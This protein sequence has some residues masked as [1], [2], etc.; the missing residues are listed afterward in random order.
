[1]RKIITLLLLPLLIL[2]LVSCE[3]RKLD[4]N[5]TNVIFYTGLNGSYVDTY[6]DVTVGDKI[7]PPEEPTRTG[8]S[9]LGWYKDI[10]YQTLWEFDVDTVESSLVLYAKWAALVWTLDFVTN[11]LLAEEFVDPSKVPATFDLNKDTYLPVLRRPGG[12]FRGWIL[13]P[14]EEYTLDMDVYR[15]SSELPI[16]LTNDFVLYPVFVN[17]K[18]LVQYQPRMAGVSV[19]APKTNVEYGSI[20]D[21]IKPLNDTE[22]HRFIGWF[23]K[24][25]TNTGDW[26]IEIKNGDYYVFASNVLLYG[27]WEEK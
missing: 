27:R 8:F 1:M 24:I 9:F 18:Y 22:T 7:D 23:S 26:G 17:N 10:Q 21:W 15:Y 11:D 4:D 14:S 13:V 16:E 25:G 20:I 3:D 2:F 12:S 19:P 5:L 6:F